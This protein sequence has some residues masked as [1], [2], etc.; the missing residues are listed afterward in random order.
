MFFEGFKLKFWYLE[1]KILGEK[2]II[3]IYCMF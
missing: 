3:R 2:W 1:E